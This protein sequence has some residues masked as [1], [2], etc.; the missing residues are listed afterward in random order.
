[1]DDLYMN[2]ALE[3]AEKAYLEDEVPVGAVI[4]KNN[5]I[6]AKSHNLKAKTCNLLNHAEIIVISKAAEILKDWR[7]TDCKMYI[8]LEPCPM[9][10]GAIQQSRIKKVFIGA[11]SNTLSNSDIV[12]RIFNNNEFCHKVEYEYLN[13]KRCSK[14]LSD[15][16]SNKR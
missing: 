12:E 15:F 10:A 4:V 1:M 8:T 5:K 16:F 3:E 2:I 14:I 11:K 9:C 6:I 7:L 13:D